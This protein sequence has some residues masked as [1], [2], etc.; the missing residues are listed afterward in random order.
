MLLVVLSLFRPFGNNL[1]LLREK[2]FLDYLPLS[3]FVSTTNGFQLEKANDRTV[4][5]IIAG[6]LGDLELES[7]IQYVIQPLQALGYDVRVLIL[8][9]SDL[10]SKRFPP[11]REPYSFVLPSQFKEGINTAPLKASTSDFYKYP[12]GNQAAVVKNNQISKLIQQRKRHFETAD[13]I[14]E[15]LGN[16]STTVLMQEPLVNLPMNLD[17]IRALALRDGCNSEGRMNRNTLG[18]IVWRAVNDFRQLQ[19]WQQAWEM[20]SQQNGN[21]ASSIEDIL[22]GTIIKLGEDSVVSE[23]NDIGSIIALVQ[24]Q[25][26]LV[27]IPCETARGHK[28]DQIEIFSAKVGKSILKLPQALSYQADSFSR[29][30]DLEGNSTDPF[31]TYLLGL[32][33]SRG[34]G[35][36]VGSNGN[37]NKWS[38][39]P[40]IF[41]TN[42][43]GLDEV[44]EPLP[45]KFPLSTASLSLENP[46]IPANKTA[47]SDR[48]RIF[49]CITGQLQRLELQNKFR[50]LIQPMKKAGY[51]VDLALVLSS[52]DATYQ[53]RKVR[54]Q[55]PHSSSFSSPEEVL[56]FI[57]K[58]ARV[59][60]PQNLTYTKPVNHPV[61]PQYLYHRAVLKKSPKIKTKQTFPAVWSV[62]E[63]ALQRSLANTIM[64]ESY[65]RCWNW[66]QQSGESY[67]WYV[68]IRDDV[69]FKK[70]LIPKKTYDKIKGTS[71]LMTSIANTNGGMNDRMAIVGPKAA[72]CYFNIPYIKMFDG[73]YL[74]DGMKN[75]ESF[76]QRQYWSNS[77]GDR[78]QIRVKPRKMINGGFID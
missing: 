17:Y 77:C 59:L 57:N 22:Q 70:P 69:G 27:A 40:A 37:P 14:L 64:M 63:E 45:F 6:V 41:P 9:Q 43:I 67:K 5:I 46:H 47:T 73:S 26:R 48:P 54:K 8:L 55:K 50:T 33:Q 35:V 68:R 34:I 44:T 29:G 31:S 2:G 3:R 38:P 15:K 21:N 58:R 36:S 62:V 56:E 16:L 76:F 49:V 25:E 78:K 18:R 42:N 75:T 1:P 24:S 66:A 52:G 51:G 71:S 53:L 32:Y 20:V 30:G 61:N 13:D 4:W 19:L 39:L 74:D 60:N 7:K 10:T 65:T 28:N 23:I 12:L 72:N 11:F